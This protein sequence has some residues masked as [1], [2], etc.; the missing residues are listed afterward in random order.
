MNYA[1]LPLQALSQVIYPKISASSHQ[2]S[3]TDLKKTYGQSVLSLFAFVLPIAL[4]LIFFNHTIIQILGNESFQEA[5][6]IIILLSIASVFKPWGRVFGLT[7]DAVGKPRVNF[8]M[9]LLSLGINVVL[10]LTL[11]PTY[12]VIGGAIATASA[13]VITILIGQLKLNKELSLHPVHT[14][15]EAAKMVF[16]NKNISSWN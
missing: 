6:V 3:G 13:I 11:I 4:V 5:S 9:L 12:G 1:E 7:L 14:V 16:K 2:N 15:V 8:L 10:N